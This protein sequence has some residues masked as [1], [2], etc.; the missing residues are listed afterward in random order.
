MYLFEI[1][2]TEAEDIQWQ[3]MGPMSM[4]LFTIEG[5]QYAI[6]FIKIANGD[7]IHRHLKNA[8]LSNNTYFV[9][10]AAM[11]NGRPVDT[12]F[13]ANN[14]FML[15]GAVMSTLVD[16]VH[17]RN[18]DTLYF[19]CETNDTKK[20]RLYERIKTKFLADYGWSQL[21]EEDAT[22]QGRM[23]HLWYVSNK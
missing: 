3:H 8:P 6:Q 15:F 21:G 7:Q 4:G 12:R 9:A 20:R 16:F 13:P 2:K 23:Q 18:I 11:D 10:F 17:E 19:G 5:Q 1:L 22:I 14:P